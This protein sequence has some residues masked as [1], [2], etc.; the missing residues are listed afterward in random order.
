MYDE[1]YHDGSGN[2]GG[3]HSLRGG[4]ECHAIVLDP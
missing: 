2:C 1:K 3:C 4:K